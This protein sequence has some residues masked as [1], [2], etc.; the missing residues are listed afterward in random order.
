MIFILIEYLILS[1][2]YFTTN[3]MIIFLCFLVKLIWLIIFH[4]L[5]KLCIHGPNLESVK[6]L[7]AWLS[8]CDSMEFCQWNSPGK[9]T[10]VCSHFLLQRIF[11]TKESIP[12]LHCRQILYHLTHQGSPEPNLTS[13]W[14]LIL[15]LY[16]L[17]SLY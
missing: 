5:K 6:V 9:S 8:L 11:A 16:L 14:F 3:K 12:S 17:G 2:A 4:M 10:R 7:V 15:F 13:S 1:N